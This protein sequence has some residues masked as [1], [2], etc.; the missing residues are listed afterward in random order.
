MTRQGASQ[1][2]ISILK[3]GWV[4]GLMA[5]VGTVFAEPSQPGI[6]VEI[7]GI[8]N[9]TGAV[10]CALFESAEGFPQ[11]MMELAKGVEPSNLRIT[12]CDNA[13]VNREDQAL[14]AWPSRIGLPLR[15][16]RA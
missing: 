8:R 11:M 2:H 14:P 5:L 4:A 15:L 13:R 12:N 7:L 3:S 9:S 16:S 1:T 6:H 10:A